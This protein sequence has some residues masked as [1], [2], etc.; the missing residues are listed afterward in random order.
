MLKVLR[1]LRRALIEFV[2]DNLTHREVHHR[3]GS[4]IDMLPFCAISRRTPP[5]VRRQRP[6]PTHAILR[7]F[8]PSHQAS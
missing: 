2:V 4:W 8:L 1:E 6:P 5:A 3:V 7:A